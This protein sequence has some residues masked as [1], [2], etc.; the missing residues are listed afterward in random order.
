MSI[1]IEPMRA[2]FPNFAG[3]VTGVDIAKGVSV[4]EAAEIEA[5]MDKYAVLVIRD[6]VIDDDQLCLV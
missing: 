6:Q 2:E 4:D 1:T 3:I 5:G